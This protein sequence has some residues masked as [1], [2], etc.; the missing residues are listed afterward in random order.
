MRRNLILALMLGTFTFT[1]QAQFDLKKITDANFV[2]QSLKNARMRPGTAELTYKQ[3][4]SAENIDDAG[5]ILH[6]LDSSLKERLVPLANLNEA[7]TAKKLPALEEVPDFEWVDGTALSFEHANQLL[8][9]NIKSDEIQ[10][11]IEL[12]E[13]YEDLQLYKHKKAAYRVG[14]NFYVSVGKK[15]Q[16]VTYDELNGVS[17]GVV[18]NRHEFNV[19]QG[20]FWSPDGSKVAFYRVDER[21]VS[22]FP[23]IENG[24]QPR[25]IRNIRYPMC[26]TDGQVVRLGV[27]DIAG[28][29]AVWIDEDPTK[30]LAGVT[31]NLDSS[32]LYVNVIHRDQKSAKLKKY[33]TA[34]GKKIGTIIEDKSDK[35]VEPLY[36]PYFID[37]H[38]FIW[39]TRT[40]G[41]QQPFLFDERAGGGL[42][43]IVD[44]EW[45]VSSVQGM[46]DKKENFYFHAN[47]NDP[48][49]RHFCRY[50][51][52]AKKLEV[53][54]TGSG[55]H[56]ANR[57]AGSSYFV[58]VISSKDKEYALHVLD[59]QGAIQYEYVALNRLSSDEIGTKVEIKKAFITSHG[60][61]LYGR[62]I[63]PPQ[64]DASK[65]YP[66]VLYVYGG[67]HLQMINNSY[68]HGAS[69]FLNYLAQQGY[70]VF[71]I[72]PRGSNSRGLAFE[73]EIFQKLGD[74]AIEDNM[75]A[76]SY[77]K[78]LPYVDK[79]RIGVHGWSFGGFVT[80]NLMMR[81][82]NTFKVGVAG[83]AVSDWTLYEIMYTERYMETF[84]TNPVGFIRSNLVN[85]VKDL[86]GSLL[87]VHGSHDDIVVEQHAHRLLAKAMEEG[88]EIDYFSYLG[89]GHHVR[90]QDS[91]HLLQKMAR[92]F[93]E[94][95]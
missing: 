90:G 74:A 95:L 42:T 47:I 25:E 61:P 54:S 5:V 83:G 9:Y 22:E 6:P 16:Q 51:I 8:S 43:K 85:H 13:G 67:P 24:T 86:Q 35:Y 80:A 53:L 60:F 29:N 32:A 56:S 19:D 7:L 33:N 20:I 31:F 84:R 78:G 57:N 77:L 88:V 64:F 66:V 79:D 92:Y 48:L 3:A 26:G 81:T 38:Q 55:Y 49:D 68:L 91:F 15:I 65:K 82:K 4:K 37:D 70:L 71:T 45:E 27:Y 52:A 34:T 30:Y 11:L 10:T 1:G 36:G 41:F 93:K 14:N 23:M 72:D 59:Q 46:D 58:D 94:R 63:Y 2:I 75:L 40:K 73:Q 28:G 21:C 17:N 89:H 18:A 44:G 76:I 50:N 62:M 39:I 87:L 69:L 12:K